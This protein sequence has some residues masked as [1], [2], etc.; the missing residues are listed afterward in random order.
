MNRIYCAV[1]KIME[2]TQ[3]IEKDV[4]LIC[5]QSEVI[6]EF[7]RHNIMTLEILNQAES[8][9]EYLAEKME[10]M[11]FGERIHIV[12]DSRSLEK[13]EVNNL[14]VLLEKR[15]YFV[16]EYFKWTNFE[17]QSEQFILEEFEAIKEYLKQLK[18]M[19]SR[20]EMIIKGQNERLS[21]LKTKVQK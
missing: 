12:Q 18:T 5:R 19:L 1:G 2:I 9:A 11:T 21:Y 6:K 17:N 13:D 20:L 4:I 15:N 3:F 16:H 8:D 7:S 10:N 14:R